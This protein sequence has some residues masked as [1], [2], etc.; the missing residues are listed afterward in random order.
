MQ[1]GLKIDTQE[2]AKDILQ[3]PELANGRY[4]CQ[5]ATIQ[6]KENLKLPRGKQ[7]TMEYFELLTRDFPEN[8]IGEGTQLLLEEKEVIVNEVFD[9]IAQRHLTM[10]EI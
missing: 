9:T 4:R 5:F 3:L 10:L 7:N 6:A 1:I 2:A 8:G